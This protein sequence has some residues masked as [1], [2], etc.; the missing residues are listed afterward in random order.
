MGVTVARSADAVAGVLGMVTER[1]LERRRCDGARLALVIE[2][3]GMAGTVSLGMCIGLEEYGLVGSFDVI[4]G[5]SAGALN[6]SYAACGQAKSA[7]ELY[8][9]GA[10]RGLIDPRRVVLGRA[11]FRLAELVELVQEHPH[12][13]GVL[14]GVPSVRVTAARVADKS[15]DVLANFASLDELRVALWASCA[16]PVLCREIVRFR[17]QPYV[18]G[19]LIESV[20]FRAA[21]RG[22]AT[23]VLVVR[24]RHAAHRVPEF[25]GARRQVLNRVLR[26]VPQ[27]AAEMVLE[28]PALYNA[29]ASDLHTGQAAARPTL[30]GQLAPPVESRCTSAYERRPR[31]LCDRIALGVAT[32]HRALANSVDANQLQ[33]L[34][35]M[36]RAA[37][38]QSPTISGKLGAPGISFER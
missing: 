28:W 14:D 29:D 4:Y 15:L 18:D 5:S 35:Q 38:H 33:G 2:G 22:G 17:G 1:A 34:L 8:L 16:N 13:A 30:V 23:H 36:A 6:A 32:V 31:R 21:L 19:G 25:R 26:G 27:N 7:A 37:E 3:G 11:P 9:L 12:R 10:A 24:S 20:P